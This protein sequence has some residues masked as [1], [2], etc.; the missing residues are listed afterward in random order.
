[1]R[2]GAVGMQQCR[3]REIGVV[4][5]ESES[6]DAVHSAVRPGRVV[7]EGLEA[8]RLLFVIA[9]ALVGTVGFEL[10]CLAGHH[11]SAVEERRVL[12]SI[13]YYHVLV[14]V[15]VVEIFDSYRCRRPTLSRL[16]PRALRQNRV[17]GA[18]VTTWVQRRAD[19]SM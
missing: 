7:V 16:L 8:V 6:G 17:D 14:L 5:G 10:V 11:G 4:V 2:C 19:G 3:C 15:C 18:V 13:C 1:M 12:C 9:D